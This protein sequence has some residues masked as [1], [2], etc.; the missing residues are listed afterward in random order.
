MFRLTQRVHGRS[1]WRKHDQPAHG[2]YGAECT[3]KVT[4]HVLIGM[5]S[6][7]SNNCLTRDWMPC[8]EYWG[9]GCGSPNV[10]N[11]C[12]LH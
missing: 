2:E 9:S 5:G 6:A 11:R 12:M 1:W 4:G 10:C 8:I 3:Y 7:S